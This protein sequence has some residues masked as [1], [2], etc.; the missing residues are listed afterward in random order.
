MEMIKNEYLGFKFKITV[1][2]AAIKSNTTGF[3]RAKVADKYLDGNTIILTYPDDGNVS[4]IV[5]P[6]MKLEWALTA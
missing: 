4:I 5:E 2:Y 6:S 1:R 3:V